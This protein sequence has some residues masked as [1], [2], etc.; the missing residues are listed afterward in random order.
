MSSPPTAS[1]SQ[2]QSH[3]LDALEGGPLDNSMDLLLKTDLAASSEAMGTEI[4]DEEVSAERV[5][6]EELLFGG[7]QV[8]Q[9]R[10]TLT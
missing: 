9:R 10:K 1:T 6:A 7:L 3:P 4:G 2:L 5:L 8:I